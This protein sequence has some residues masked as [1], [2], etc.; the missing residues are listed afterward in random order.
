MKRLLRSLAKRVAGWWHGELSLAESEQVRASVRAGIHEGFAPTLNQLKAMANT[1]FVRCK[2]CRHQ[3][4]V[5]LEKQGL[6]RCSACGLPI[7][8]VRYRGAR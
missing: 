8:R 5:T 2:A 4:A 6:R 1:T 3:N 7:A